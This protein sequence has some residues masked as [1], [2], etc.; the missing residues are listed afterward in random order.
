MTKAAAG[1][2]LGPIWVGLTDT[3]EE[4]KWRYWS[5]GD[6]FDASTAAYA[7]GNNNSGTSQNC[8]Y[9]N[10]SYQILYDA[11]CS[12]NSFYALCEIESNLC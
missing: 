9:V 2:G 5:S 6:E 3:Y 1:G 12:S 11:S 10:A 7:W 8:A 4:N